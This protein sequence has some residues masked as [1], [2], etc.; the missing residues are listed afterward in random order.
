M[1]LALGTDIWTQNNV[2][3]KA[4]IADKVTQQH[5]TSLRLYLCISLNCI[6]GPFCCLS[7]S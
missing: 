5:F 1:G 6:N 3:R 2:I 7:M 4:G